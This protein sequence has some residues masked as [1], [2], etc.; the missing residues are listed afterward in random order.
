[1]E[2]VEQRM[3]QLAAKAPT[4]FT[5]LATPLNLILI[6]IT[7]YTSYLLYAK[8]SAPATLPREPPAVVFRTFTPR[9]LL[10]YNG[11]DGMP[12][13]LAVRGRVFDVTS[14][15][16]FYGPGGPY[17][18]FA[19]RDAS[20]GLSLHS[21]DEDVLTKD[22]DGPLDTLEGLDEEAMDSLRGWEERFESKYL[23]VGR[24]VAAGG[25]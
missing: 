23:V 21:F 12:V 20:R 10:P 17:E 18:N 5:G 2:Y 24:L 4:E 9:A 8:P 13:Y 22:L 1:M 16:N 7:L 25:A 19:G 14:G 3:N 11:T 15:R 6:A